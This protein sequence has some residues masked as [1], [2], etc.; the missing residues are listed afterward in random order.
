MRGGGYAAG[1]GRGKIADGG[2]LGKGASEIGR[3]ERGIVTGG[4]RHFLVGLGRV[5]EL[6]NEGMMLGGQVSGWGAAELELRALGGD[7]VVFWV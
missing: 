2:R 5:M 3:L 6:P 4:S 1:D 7:E